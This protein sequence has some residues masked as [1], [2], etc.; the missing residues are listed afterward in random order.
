MSFYLDRH[1][2]HNN[3]M[4]SHERES[5]IVLL[6]IFDGMH[7]FVP[8]SL[9]ETLI[10]IAHMQVEVFEIVTMAC[11]QKKYCKE[12]KVFVNSFYGLFAKEIL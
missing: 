8:D 11:S 5:Q 6:Y 10:V 3:S 12:V 1:F 2:R 4:S 9:L 7:G